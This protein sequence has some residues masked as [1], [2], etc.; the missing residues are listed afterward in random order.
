MI[1]ILKVIM[2]FLLSLLIEP[3]LYIILFLM[4]GLIYSSTQNNQNETAVKIL[5]VLCGI[6]TVSI[7]IIL[8][9]RKNKKRLDQK[10]SKIEEMKESLTQGQTLT[11]NRG[12]NE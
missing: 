7:P 9:Y 5:L 2:A 4:A 10:K 1:K 3:F 12:K 6:L 11:D 8:N